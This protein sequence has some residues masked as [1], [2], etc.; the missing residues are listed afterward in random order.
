MLWCA[1]PLRKSSNRLLS[2]VFRPLAKPSR[3]VMSRLEKQC[4]AECAC[5]NH[6][7]D[8]MLT[9]HITS[10]SIGLLQ[11]FEGGCENC[12]QVPQAPENAPSWSAVG[13][14]ACWG[15]LM[16]TECSVRTFMHTL[17]D[18]VLLKSILYKSCQDRPG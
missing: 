6:S 10:Q 16:G 14:C 11:M 8:C 9:L 15:T 7:P 5:P 18:Y 3:E 12:L 2:S 1:S 17:H 4:L 13:S